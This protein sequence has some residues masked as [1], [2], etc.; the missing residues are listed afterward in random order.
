METDTLTNQEGHNSLPAL[1]PGKYTLSV[2]KAGFAPIRE[3]NLVLDVQRVARIDFKLKSVHRQE[4]SLCL[5]HLAY[6]RVGSA[7]SGH[8]GWR[9]RR[10]F[11]GQRG[12]SRSR[13]SGIVRGTT[14]YR[15]MLTRQREGPAISDPMPLEAGIQMLAEAGPEQPAKRVVSP[16]HGIGQYLNNIAEQDHRRV[17]F[18]VSAMLGLKSLQHVRAVIDGIYLVQKLKKGQYGVPFS[19]GRTSRDIWRCVLAS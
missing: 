16:P 14:G 13:A 17:K 19:F 10:P 12:R 5:R 1:P 6:V 4:S 18:R 11:A 3:E 7:R 9:P 2:Q 8:S 15:L